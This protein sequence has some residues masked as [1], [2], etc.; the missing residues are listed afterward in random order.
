MDTKQANIKTWEVC[1]SFGEEVSLKSKGKFGILAVDNDVLKL[2]GD[3]NLNIQKQ[4]VLS[5]DKVGWPIATSAI[6]IKTKDNAIIFC[7]E[8]FHPTRHVVFA[9]FQG[10]FQKELFKFLLS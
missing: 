4:E 1:Y 10:R 5:M 2:T 7:A 8:V 6:R 9:N 3:D